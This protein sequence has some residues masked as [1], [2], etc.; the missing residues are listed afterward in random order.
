MMWLTNEVAFFSSLHS[1]AA[2]SLPENK[3][4]QPTFR[5]SNLNGGLGFGDRSIILQQ[6]VGH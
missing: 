4:K 6:N 3:A 5:K 2:N 1:L